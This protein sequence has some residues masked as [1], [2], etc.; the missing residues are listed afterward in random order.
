MNRTKNKE[1]VNAIESGL[2]DLKDKI[3][4]MSDDESKIEKLYKIKSI[5]K[6]ILEFNRQNQERQGLKILVKDQNT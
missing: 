1:F 5:V 6:K 4:E 2:S 3:K